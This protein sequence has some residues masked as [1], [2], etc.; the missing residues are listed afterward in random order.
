MSMPQ[1]P[2][3]RAAIR[4]TRALGH[5]AG[6]RDDAAHAARASA[7]AASSLHEAPHAIQADWHAVRAGTTGASRREGR[8]DP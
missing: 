2:S 8:S 3:T 1:Q 6:G 5:A 7:R 4:R